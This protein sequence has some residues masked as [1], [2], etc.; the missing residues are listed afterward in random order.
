[1]HKHACKNTHASLHIY[2]I[3]KNA[4]RPW[5]GQYI[6]TKKEVMYVVCVWQTKH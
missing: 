3:H 5:S 2:V 4:H 1:M 6:N